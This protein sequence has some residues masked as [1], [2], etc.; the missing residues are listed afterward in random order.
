MRLL[1]T[2][3][4]GFIGSHFVRTALDGGYAGHEHTRVTVLDKLTYAGNRANLP[5]SHARLDFVQGDVCDHRLLHELLPG[6]DAVVHFAAESH[7]DRSVLSAAEFVRTNVMGTQTLL[8]ACAATGI[9]RFVHVSTDEVYGSITE[10]SWTEEW[11][12]LPNS[13]YAASKA[14]SDLIARAYWRTHGLSVSITRCS[15]NYGPY[16][17]PEKLIPLFVTNLLEGERVPLY[18]DGRNIREWL[19]VDDHCR[20][21]ALVLDGGR[22]GEV[23]NVGGGNERTNVDITRRL[24]D[25]CGA[26]ESMIRRVADRKGHDLRYSLDETKIREELGYTP[27][28]SFEQG[29]ADTVAWYRDNPDWWKPVKH[30]NDHV[31]R[32][33]REGSTR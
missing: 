15:N 10:G 2:G 21:I 31:G 25:L 28:V 8:D 24:L 14:A 22:P 12:L 16:Q 13:P 3:G 4:A 1:V 32:Q 11:P 26:D 7:V 18:G 33:S 20:A 27:R 23:Y 17:H 5:R 29:L 19:H 30:R 9:H 6:H